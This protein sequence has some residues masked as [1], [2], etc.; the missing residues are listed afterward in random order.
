MEDAWEEEMS[1]KARHQ[2]SP[3]PARVADHPIINFMNFV[4]SA[5][6]A[7][8]LH[9]PEC[10]LGNAA[11]KLPVGLEVVPVNGPRRPINGQGLQ[12]HGSTMGNRV[13]AGVIWADIDCA[14]RF[15]DQA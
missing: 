8:V 9:P 2:T 15:S 3:P 10:A 7:V 12:H 6:V 4:N 14:P 11:S 5:H 13:G 1:I